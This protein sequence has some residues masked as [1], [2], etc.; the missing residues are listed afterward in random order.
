MN[1]EQ[2]EEVYIHLS[3]AAGEFAMNMIEL[4]R[5]KT[6]LRARTLFQVADLRREE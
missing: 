3:A 5:L 1:I 2:G 6:E 4:K